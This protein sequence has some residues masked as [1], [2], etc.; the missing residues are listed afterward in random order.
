MQTYVL[1]NRNAHNLTL[2]HTIRQIHVQANMT[3]I[4]GMCVMVLVNQFRVNRC[5]WRD[6]FH[7]CFLVV[8]PNSLSQPC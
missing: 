3:H 2:T 4:I 6:D 1:R 5:G 7:F 8:Q